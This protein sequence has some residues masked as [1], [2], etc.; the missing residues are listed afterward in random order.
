ML[1][2]RFVVRNGSLRGVTGGLCQGGWEM[3]ECV[4]KGQKKEKKKV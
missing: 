3:G 4:Y 2:S 1:V